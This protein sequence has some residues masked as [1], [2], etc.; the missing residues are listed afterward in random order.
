MFETEINKMFRAE[1]LRA[2]TEVLE[3]KD[4]EGLLD[5]SGTVRDKVTELGNWFSVQKE[6][7][8]YQRLPSRCEI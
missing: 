2:S 5:L 4:T 8:R 6:T 1:M 3:V 7:K